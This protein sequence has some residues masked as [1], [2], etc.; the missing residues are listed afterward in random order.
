MAGNGDG[1][2]VKLHSR[3]TPDK[4]W[5]VRVFE[6]LT[7]TVVLES[8]G[9]SLTLGQIYAGVQLPEAQAFIAF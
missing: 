9:C 8:C 6:A 1:V 5:N 3:Q 7:D 2:A 4:L